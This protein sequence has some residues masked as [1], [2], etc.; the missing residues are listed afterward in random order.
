MNVL[1]KPGSKLYAL[2]MQVSTSSYNKVT[3]LLFSAIHCCLN[4]VVACLCLF[5]T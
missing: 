3:P 2:N 4:L 5:Q 1:Q